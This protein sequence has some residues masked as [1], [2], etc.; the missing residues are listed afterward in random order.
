MVEMTAGGVDESRLMMDQRE[1]KDNTVAF[2]NLETSA[3]RTHVYRL[4]LRL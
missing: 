4:R 3:S 2:H 1:G